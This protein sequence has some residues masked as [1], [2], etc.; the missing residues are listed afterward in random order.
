MKQF[1]QQRNPRERI[2]ILLCI[3]V[4]GIVLWM[5]TTP[6]DQGGKRLLSAQQARLKNREAEKQMQQLATKTAQI[7]PFIERYAYAESP[8]TLTPHVIRTLQGYAKESG[9][10]L[11]EIKPLRT[12][13]IG[14]VMRVPLSVRFSTAEWNRTAI[15]FL[16][17]VEDP[18]GKLVVE[19]LNITSPDPKSRT[20]DVEAQI[21]FFTREISTDSTQGRPKTTPQN[22]IGETG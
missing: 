18:N 2:L 14:N 15:A 7:K 9:L 20:V 16:Y 4:V 21:A 19:K 13:R 10:H 1:W 17:R 6:T 12:R 11:R 3:V 22:P 8:E 5:V